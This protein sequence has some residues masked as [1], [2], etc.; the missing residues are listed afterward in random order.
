MLKDRDMD[1]IIKAGTLGTWNTVFPANYSAQ[2]GARVIVTED[3]DTSKGEM[4][5]IEWIDEL[6]TSD[7]G[8]QN[9]GGYFHEDFEFDAEQEPVRDVN[10]TVE[11]I[12][13]SS[14]LA[15]YIIIGQLL[16]VLPLFDDH[17]TFDDNYSNWFTRPFL[18]DS[19]YCKYGWTVS[20]SNKAIDLCVEKGL[21]KLV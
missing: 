1:K 14:E 8:R 9:D 6:A 2:P 7:K 3:C 17:Q 21:F 5:Q 4:I 20:E 16:Q 13:E 19:C 12:V 15:D 18:Q 10:K 11:V